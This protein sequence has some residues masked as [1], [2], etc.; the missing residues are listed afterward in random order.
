MEDTIFIKKGLYQ[1]LLTL[2]AHPQ[3]DVLEFKSIKLL[4]CVCAI[5]AILFAG[6]A[7]AVTVQLKSSV[8]TTLM[9]TNS[10][11]S[12]LCLYLNHKNKS[13]LS[14]YL[15]STMLPLTIVFGGAYAKSIGVTNNITLYLSPRI[16]ITL[17]LVIPL[18]LFGYRQKKEMILALMPGLLVFVLFDVIHH[19]F[20][21]Y[22]EDL[23]Y[24]PSTYS[25]FLVMISLFLF[26][27]LFGITFLQKTNYLTEK[28]LAEQ[29]EELHSLNLIIEAAKD[30]IAEKEERLSSLIENQGAAV[31]LLDFDG[32]FT[33]WNKE[34][35]K[36]LQVES[37]AGQTIYRF[38]DQTEMNGLFNE[39]KESKKGDKLFREY[40]GL[41]A[42]SRTVYIHV[43]V[44]P[45][46]DSNGVL[47]SISG[48]F[49]DITALKRA[50]IKMIA[51]QNKVEKELKNVKDSIYYAKT[52][53]ESLLV[54]EQSIKEVLPD[55]FLFFQPKEIVSGDFYYIKK[56]NDYIIFTVA[57]CTGHGVPGG[58]ISMLG[59]TYID[60]IIQKKSI[61]SSNEALNLL[62]NRIKTTFQRFGTENNNGMDIAF[63]SVDTKTGMLQYSGANNPIIIVREGELTI[64][65]PTKNPIGFFPKEIPFEK[66]EI[67]LQKGDMLYLFT[68]GYQDQFG[69]P[70]N[71]KFMS[72]K[73]RELLLEI[74][75]LDCP[76]KKKVLNDVLNEWMAG[77]E[78]IDDITILG[79]HW[80]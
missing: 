40:K 58:F 70:Q 56:V 50:E 10:V 63:C 28:M 67:Q 78:Q 35:E 55:S 44:A 30:I 62:R 14:K 57:D 41:D 6:L 52:I 26:F 76:E 1:R 11:L 3:M 29:N 20:G 47:S 36:I 59:I 61:T 68:D 43:V 75:H 15:L 27:I 18:L 37:L 51:K 19:S 34:A 7:I 69:G 74:N 80:Q 2:G 48:V 8:I 45:H 64:Y 33:F 17:T 46:F 22:L 13:N 49:R 4:N 54:S 42:N 71:K 79:I 12:F 25:L 23:S 24:D 73:F 16:L 66:M 72:K 60:Q 31:C 39:I 5:S 77:T 32:N 65:K 9:V 38:F 53:Q 21:V